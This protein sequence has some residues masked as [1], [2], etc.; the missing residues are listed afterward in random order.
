MKSIVQN[1]IIMNGEK[2]YKKIPAALWLVFL[3]FILFNN[4][5]NKL[6]NKLQIIYNNY[7]NNIPHNIYYLEFDEVSIQH[8]DL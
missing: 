6:Q 3:F 1:V 4:F 2:I 7:N 5:Y 8:E